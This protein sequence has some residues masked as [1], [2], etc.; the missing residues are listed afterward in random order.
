MGHHHDGLGIGVSD[1]IYLHICSLIS[2]A[3][4]K[5]DTFDILLNTCS[6]SIYPFKLTTLIGT[7]T[8]V[9]SGRNVS[10]PNPLFFADAIADPYRLFHALA[11]LAELRCNFPSWHAR[12]NTFQAKQIFPSN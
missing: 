6:H 1:K 4:L 11:R 12:G 7:L 8:L 2:L 5:A 3:E 10:I 9:K